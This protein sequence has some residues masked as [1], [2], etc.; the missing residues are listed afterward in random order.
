MMP[1]LPILYSTVLFPVRYA[2]HTRT[3]QGERVSLSLSLSHDRRLEHLVYEGGGHR[4]QQHLG[5]APPHC[6]SLPVR[7]AIRPVCVCTLWV[8]QGGDCHCQPPPCTIPHMYTLRILQGEV[9]VQ[10]QSPS[11][12][13]TSCLYTLYLANCPLVLQCSS[14]TE[15]SFGIRMYRGLRTFALLDDLF[16]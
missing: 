6:H 7:Y 3:P 4:R 11:L 2:I 13:D 5:V 16:L 8:L 1:G 15:D 10:R 12:Y 9:S 14:D